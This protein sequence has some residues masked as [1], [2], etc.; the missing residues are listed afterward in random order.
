MHHT[1]EQFGV[2]GAREAFP[3][4]SLSRAGGGWSPAPQRPWPPSGRCSANVAQNQYNSYPSH[5]SSIGHSGKSYCPSGSPRPLHGKLDG[6]HS[7]VQALQHEQPQPRVW[8]QL[9]QIY[10]SEY[11][12]EDAIKCYQSAV[13]YAS[14]Y[15]YSDL[16][17]RINRLQQVH[18]WKL[19]SNPPPNRQRTLPTLQEVWNI[20]QQKRNYNSTK[21]G[22]QLKRAAG[23]GDH[24]AQQ[25]MPPLH[26]VVRPSHGNEIPSP[27][28]R[29]RS[30]SPDQIQS[31]QQVHHS[32][33]QRP[34]D[35]AHSSLPPHG[36]Y[37]SQKA[38]AAWLH[39]HKESWSH[40]RKD[41]PVNVQEQRRPAADA[42]PGSSSSSGPHGNPTVHP[43]TTTTGQP[44][45]GGPVPSRGEPRG[46]Q[47]CAGHEAKEAQRPRAEGEVPP[48]QQRT[49]STEHWKPQQ[50]PNPAGSTALLGCYRSSEGHPQGPNGRLDRGPHTHQGSALL[51]EAPAI[52]T[53]A[54]EACSATH[55]AHLSASPKGERCV[56]R[57]GAPEPGDRRRDGERCYWGSSR[58]RAPTPLDG[59][60]SCRSP[61][62]KVEELGHVAPA[63][64]A[65]Q[66]PL[67][68]VDQAQGP[69]PKTEQKPNPK[70]PAVARGPTWE[71][72]GGGGSAWPSREQPKSVTSPTP[73]DPCRASQPRMPPLSGPH[74]TCTD[75][76]RGRAAPRPDQPGSAAKP[77]PT[78]PTSVSKLS[79]GFASPPR[80]AEAPKAKPGHGEG[81]DG[82]WLPKP[83]PLTCALSGRPAAP[84]PPPPASPDTK[85][86]SPDPAAPPSP[87]AGM[88]YRAPSP[89]HG[90]G[91]AAPVPACHKAARVLKSLA[92]ALEGQH[93][94]CRVHAKSAA[95]PPG[96]PAAGKGLLL[97]VAPGDRASSSSPES[98]MWIKAI[99]TTEAQKSGANGAHRH[100]HRHRHRPRPPPPPPEPPAADEPATSPCKVESPAE[101]PGLEP[102]TLSPPGLG[103][104][105]GNA[106][107]ANRP[108]GKTCEA[109]RAV[110]P[111]PPPPAAQREEGR[112]Q[113]QHRRPKHRSKHSSRDRSRRRNRG[114]K[115]GKGKQRRILGNID[116][117]S[118]E[119]Q[120]REKVKAEVPKVS[121]P[122]PP[123]SAEE[124]EWAEARRAEP[125][126]PAGKDPDAGGR[127]ALG[128]S[129]ILRVKPF[130]EGTTKELKIKLIK[131]ESGDRE[132]FIASEVEERRIR[133]SDLTIE[134]SGADVIRAC[135]STKL[136]GK[137]TAS[138]VLPAHS[139]KPGCLT[140][141]QPLREKLNP[142]T[143]S[144]Y[145]ESKRDA[146]SPVLQQFCTD[147]KT[148]ITVI[149]GLAGSLRLNLGLFSTKTLVE[150]NGEH[151]V[152]VRTQLQQPSDENWDPS[153]GSQTWPCESSR[154]HTT[155][156][157]YAQYQ[158]SSFQESLQ[159]DKESDEE[160]A[161]AESE[162]P[163]D[164]PETVNRNGQKVPLKVIKFGTNIDLS[165]P[166]LWKPQLQEL[167]KLPAFMRVSSNGNMLSHVGHTIYGMNTVQLYMKVP[168]SRTPG[169][170]ENNN[171][172]SVN[173]NIGP[174]DC[175]W[176]A[177]PEG[178]WETISE[179]CDRHGV[180]Y[181][182]GSWWPVLDDLYAAKIP[183]YR[184]IQ[185][186]GDLVWINAG[187]VHWVQATGW[188]NNIAWNVG[189]LTAYQYQ[190]A[191]ERYE[192]NK[193][194]KVKS[195][196]PMIHVTWNAA[197][198]VKVT[199]PELYRMIKY[200]LMTSL[201]Q[202][203]LLRDALTNSGKK[204]I[205]QSRVKEEPAYYCNECELEVFNI[206]FV[207]SE[208]NNRKSYIVHCEDCAR[209]RSPSLLNVVILEQYKMDDLVQA[210]DHFI[211]TP[212]SGSSR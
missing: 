88:F 203:Q 199:D 139:V 159:E 200:C 170:Q 212:Q 189:P 129:N 34:G 103:R 23:P 208:N 164:A 66:P 11:E 51:P 81:V 29:K 211:L 56:P 21:N 65:P 5:M 173:I 31:H 93:L 132:T 24:C 98:E 111:T 25:S 12:L 163:V 17:A 207:T 167:L 161:E 55:S 38:G 71:R 115:S 202:C 130:P 116:L 152:E 59:Q 122:A 133:L 197:R 96:A 105:C 157:K 104:P 83:P 126:A 187:T 188:C 4:D 110:S 8:E 35:P 179:F 74:R 162:K 193:V 141:Q 85:P 99:I 109:E 192:W 61:P 174:G 107:S 7:C 1:A 145:L 147:A 15:S 180:D 177:V 166:K 91:K 20:L 75:E 137:F 69:C 22:C 148:P 123:P 142:P 89:G 16:T 175:E 84:P 43:V 178:Y 79:R 150:A 184:F 121:K 100:H 90:E 118:K 48:H 52:A 72:K 112:P 32:G 205:F 44:A 70:D 146:F 204:I 106:T 125:P 82:R 3:I 36:Q 171:F 95:Q 124:P 196:V 135:K 127:S 94:A 154:S 156:A 57:R 149:R 54:P 102:E 153:G 68:P 64:R 86:T 47:P 169:H 117:Q 114:S 198:T 27:V 87:R 181:L 26:Q 182:T 33:M 206:L 30:R 40:G 97:P 186:P 108:A 191:L 101:R 77:A 63:R 138:C 58:E 45:C 172:C 10:E 2:R 113:G 119:I 14:G 144:I 143:P 42:V 134:S 49:A 53:T 39:A 19:R 155:I 136:K 183:V 60:P 165:D 9:G 140:E 80:L 160:E 195:I 176:F 128:A 76:S 78:L 210:Y 151:T 201:K 131:V 92:S 62:A 46:R 28:K 6:I 67:T 168:G 209:Q 190:L 41:S 120:A 18:V 37:P 194:K 50:G 13:R 158:A 73:R 185:R